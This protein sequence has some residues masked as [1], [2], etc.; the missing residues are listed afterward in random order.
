MFPE[1]LGRV[2]NLVSVF[3][4]GKA[5]ATGRTK[6]HGEKMEK[7]PF[8]ACYSCGY[9]GDGESPDRPVDVGASTTERDQ[10]LANVGRAP[11][12]ASRACARARRPAM[13]N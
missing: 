2:K 6:H 5:D 1:A 11:P 3:G 4:T 13:T 7:I 8:A 10:S 9:R 12:G